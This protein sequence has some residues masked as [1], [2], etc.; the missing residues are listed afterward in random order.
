[1]GKREIRLEVNITINE[2]ETSATDNEIAYW[3]QR[4]LNGEITIQGSGTVE[5]SSMDRIKEE[6]T[7]DSVKAIKVN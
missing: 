7:I 4:V 1:M 5:W 3:A 2:D 6:I